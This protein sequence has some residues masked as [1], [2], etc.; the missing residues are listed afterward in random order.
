MLQD[1]AQIQTSTPRGGTKAL[2][3]A[4][5][6]TV[7]KDTSGEVVDMTA[8]TARYASQAEEELEKPR[9]KRVRSQSTLRTLQ[10]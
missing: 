5:G 7:V 9:Q 1:Q 6:D 10:R 3:S 2:V 8:F 4:L